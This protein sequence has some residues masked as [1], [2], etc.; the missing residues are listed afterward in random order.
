M[1]FI[2]QHEEDTSAGSTI[3][4]LNDNNLT[5]KIIR[6]FENDELPNPQKTKIQGVI[7]CGGSMN[8]DQE[9]IF[10]WLITEKKWIKEI[11]SN[12]IKTFGL[13][14][15]AQLI[16]D[17][18][19]AHVHAMGYAEAGWQSVEVNNKLSLKVFQ[20]HSYCFEKHPNMHVFASNEAW[21]NQ[22]YQ[23]KDI[24]IGTQFHPEADAEWIKLCLKSKLPEG[25]YCQTQEQILKDQLNLATMRDWYFQLLNSHF[26]SASQS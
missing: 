25:R 24:A 6:L 4:W 13:C 14:L 20:W 7:I 12:Q 2:V 8:V 19:G 23:F 5:Y 10:P 22:A 18:L 1:Y 21:K 17:V 3:D 26:R 9:N 15:G 11:L 16:A